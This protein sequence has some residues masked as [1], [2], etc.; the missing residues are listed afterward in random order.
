M[1]APRWGTEREF[2]KI[3]MA[4]H[5]PLSPSFFYPALLP[6]SS[7]ISIF[8]FLIIIIIILRRN[9]YPIFSRYSIFRIKNFWQTLVEKSFLRFNRF[10]SSS[11]ILFRG[12]ISNIQFD[13]LSSHEKIRRERSLSFTWSDGRRDLEEF[14][15][16]FRS[17]LRPFSSSLPGRS[18]GEREKKQRRREDADVN[19]TGTGINLWITGEP[20]P[21][22]TVCERGNHEESRYSCGSRKD[23]FLLLLLLLL[24]CSSSS[25]FLAVPPPSFFPRFRFSF[26][27]FSITAH[28]K[29]VQIYIF[30]LFVRFFLC[31]GWCAQ[32]YEQH[33]CFGAVMNRDFCCAICL[34]GLR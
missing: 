1:M 21:V 33:A 10:Y 14:P 20:V 22:Y 4:T 11:M 16:R 23:S 32:F 27:L 2:L 7:L 31:R 28:D 9:T 5:T 6:T 18:S 12:N 17:H 13:Y 26:R 19:S 30:L 34:I 15:F 25:V 24:R 8:F 3:L 29:S